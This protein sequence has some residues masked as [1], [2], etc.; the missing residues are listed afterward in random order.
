MDTRRYLVKVEGVVDERRA[1]DQAN[2]LREEP[3]DQANNLREEPFVL[4]SS[5]MV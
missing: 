5:S 4:L 2:N 3:L 1:K